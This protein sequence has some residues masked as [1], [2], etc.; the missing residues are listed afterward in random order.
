MLNIKF[1]LEATELNTLIEF[2]NYSLT[3]KNLN[4]LLLWGNPDAVYH[5]VVERL[6]SKLLRR[7]ATLLMKSNSTNIMVVF[8]SREILAFM[9]W[10][11]QSDYRTDMLTDF[12]NKTSKEVGL[13]KMKTSI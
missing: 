4:T 10:Y 1:K 11:E 12:Y 9:E 6:K 2:C 7:L 5:L 8:D 13:L 3:S